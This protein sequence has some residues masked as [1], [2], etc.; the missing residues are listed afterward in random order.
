MKPLEIDGIN[1]N[2]LRENERIREN[3]FPMK[4]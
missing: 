4:I 2:K 3:K 1:E